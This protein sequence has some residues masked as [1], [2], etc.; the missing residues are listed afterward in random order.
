MLRETLSP[1]GA[2]EGLSEGVVH[3]LAGSAEVEFDLV[4]MRPVIQ[5]TRGELGAVVHTNAAGK[6]P[7]HACLC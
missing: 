2:V 7:S 5:D 6:H 4:P 1:N 3:G